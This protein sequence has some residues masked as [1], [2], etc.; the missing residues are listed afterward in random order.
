MPSASTNRHSL[1]ARVIATQCTSLANDGDLPL[2]DLGGS[3][4]EMLTSSADL[5]QCYKYYSAT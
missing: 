4:E 3:D 5:K 1:S 2:V